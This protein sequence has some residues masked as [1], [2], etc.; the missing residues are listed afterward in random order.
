MQRT[1]IYTLTSHRYYCKFVVCIK[2]TCETFTYPDALYVC[3]SQCSANNSV[4]NLNTSCEGSSHYR[5]RLQSLIIVF[6]PHL[7]YIVVQ[8]LV[9]MINN[10]WNIMYF[11]NM[12]VIF[13]AKNVSPSVQSTSPVQW[14]ID[15]KQA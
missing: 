9:S 8:H 14:L 3:E 7:V 4:D 13:N 15:I 11:K 5:W 10:L 6:T 12:K 1:K 2:C